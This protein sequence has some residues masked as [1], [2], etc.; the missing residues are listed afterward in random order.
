MVYSC[1][2]EVFCC[3]SDYRRFCGKSELRR[4]CSKELRDCNGC[5]LFLRLSVQVFIA[6]AESVC[7]N[8]SR[9]TIV[10]ILRGGAGVSFPGLGFGQICKTLFV[11]VQRRGLSFPGGELGGVYKALLAESRCLCGIVFIKKR[12]LLC[13]SFSK[14]LRLAYANQR[15]GDK[16]ES[17]RA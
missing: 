7:Y 13:G 1:G 2:G 14:K 10:V 16:N 3:R 15:R 11:K 8:M 17:E 5:C 6:N 4:N 12:K 9:R